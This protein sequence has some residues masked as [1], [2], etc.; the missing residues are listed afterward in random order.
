MAID[1]D[2]DRPLERGAGCAVPF[3][4]P[5]QQEPESSSKDHGIP[6]RDKGHGVSFREGFWIGFD[7]V[8]YNDDADYADQSNVRRSVP[9]TII[10]LGGAA[11]SWASST[12]ICATL[13]TAEAE[14]AALGEGVKEA[15]FTGAV[16]SFIFSP[17]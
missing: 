8:D 10:T 6:P 1:L 7:C 3:S 2:T 4:Q 9:G 13:S 15:S 14:Y 11:D 16:I 12:Q 5:Q 17:D